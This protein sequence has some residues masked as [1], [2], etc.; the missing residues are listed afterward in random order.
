[1]KKIRN[2]ILALMLSCY[3]V[4][5][6]VSTD[7]IEVQAFEWALPAIGIEEALKWLLALLG[8]S[9]AGK[10]VGDNVNWTDLKE[11]CIQH[12]Y[13]MGNSQ[14]AV[15]KWWNDILSGSLDQASS[16]WTAFKDWVQNLA[17]Y[18]GIG[19]SSD[20]I[21]FVQTCIPSCNEVRGISS[22]F[23]FSIAYY[24]LINGE[25]RFY[26]LK[27]YTYTYSSNKTINFSPLSTA[28]CYRTTSAYSDNAS[29]V[30]FSNTSNS[31][32]IL[33]SDSSITYVYGI[34]DLPSIYNVWDL[35][36]NSNDYDVSKYKENVSDIALTDANATSDSIPD[37]LPLPW[38]NAGD[39]AQAI[40]DLIEGLMEKV[41]EGVI[42]LSDYMEKVQ[43]ILGLLAID[44]STDDVLPVADED[45]PIKLPDVVAD[46]VSNTEFSLE[47]LQK[48]FPFCIPWDIKDFITLLVAQPVAPTIHYPIQNGFTHQTEYI[49][50]DFDDWE[51][52]VVLFRYIFDFLL[53]IG[54]LLLARSLVGAGGSD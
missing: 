7:Y 38:D 34:A 14:V 23:E 3:M 50:I 8:V 47:G 42:S 18:N 6:V 30:S 32:S 49:D 26:F 17:Q 21:G 54:L 9:I 52:I 53:I 48:V 31:L 11:D 35:N 25:Y 44:T 40:D 51:P 36:S 27:D 24:T 43:D 41:A 15:S 19:S 22:D 12:Q 29:R 37:A 20:V 4:F 46:N 33:S 5:G 28:S 16:C 10:A 39:S 45:N 13:E 2:R 1:M